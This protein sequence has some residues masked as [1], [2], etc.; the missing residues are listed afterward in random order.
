MLHDNT[1]GG[2]DSSP[3]RFP[4]TTM[5]LAV[6]PLARGSADPLLRVLGGGRRAAG[7]SGEILYHS[8]D[9]LR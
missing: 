8:S 6:L 7:S 4:L 1:T 9:S 3:T 5:L 2:P